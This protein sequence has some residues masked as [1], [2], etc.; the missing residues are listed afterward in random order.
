MGTNYYVKTD[1]KTL[2]L[3]KSSAGWTFALRVYPEL[4]I[5]S[6]TDW[7]PLLGYGLIE[8]EYGTA[9]TA[10]EILL[11]IL[12]R[13]GYMVPICSEEF[14][15]KNHAV[16]GPRNLLRCVID[17]PHRSGTRCIGHG[18]GNL[19]LHAGRLLLKLPFR[20]NGVTRKCYPEISA[21]GSK[22]LS[23]SAAFRRP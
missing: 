19:R 8:D 22:E 14:L 17:P 4:S 12:N 1:E 9:Y 11:I 5:N 16:L 3:G 6:L 7:V 15:S 10:G 23:N 18:E 20:K 2:H 13:R 21:I